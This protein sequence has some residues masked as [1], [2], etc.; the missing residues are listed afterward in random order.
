[1]WDLLPDGLGIPQNWIVDGSGKWRWQQVGF[2][3][4]DAQ[5]WG[6]KLVERLEQTKP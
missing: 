4:D 6:K 3:T 5:E 2:G 1:V